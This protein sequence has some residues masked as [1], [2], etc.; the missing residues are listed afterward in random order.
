MLTSGDL[1]AID[2]QVMKVLLSY[3]AKNKPIAAPWQVPQTIMALRHSLGIEKN[4]YIVVSELGVS[5]H[6]TDLALSPIIRA[7]AVFQ[8]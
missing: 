8:L 6:I 2:V 1:A 7:F 3:E 5:H 4:G